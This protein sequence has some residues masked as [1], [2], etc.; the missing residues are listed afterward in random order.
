[1]G[2]DVNLYAEGRITDEEL[3]AANE[4]MAQRVYPRD[5]YEHE[6][7]FGSLVR[8]NLAGEWERIEFRTLSRYYGPGYER[9]DWPYIHNVI[10]CMRAALPSCK[11][12]YGGDTTDYGIE[13]T[14]ELMAE[15]WMHW[16]SADGRRLLQS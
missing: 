15:Y 4:F 14:D 6:I 1:M 11:V 5:D 13:V 8:D 12:F 10:V 9:G 7:G 3:A 16:L 2:V